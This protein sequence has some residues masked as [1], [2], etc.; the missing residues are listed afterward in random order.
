MLRSLLS[1]QLPNSRNTNDVYAYE[2]KQHALAFT[3]MQAIMA[4]L[5]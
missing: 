4:N 1:M 2:T 3:W 5:N